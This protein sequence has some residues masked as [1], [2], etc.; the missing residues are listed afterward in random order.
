MGR[1]TPP[2]SLARNINEVTQ[3]TVLT[4]VL[5]SFH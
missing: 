1:Y 5:E 4:F 3:I 2:L